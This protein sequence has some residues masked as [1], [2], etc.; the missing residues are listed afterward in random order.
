MP[1]FLNNINWFEKIGLFLFALFLYSNIVS[2]IRYRKTTFNLGKGKIPGCL[3]D[4]PVH[5][6]LPEAYLKSKDK[7]KQFTDLLITGQQ[8]EL[9]LSQD[10]INNLYTKGII[11]NK[12][13]AGRYLYYQIKDNIILERLIE[14]PLF[15]SPKSYRMRIKEI[16]FSSNNL[17][18]YSRIIEEYGRKMNEEK[19]IFSF[20]TSTLILFIFGGL[21]SPDCTFYKHEETVEY[22][23]AMILLEKIKNI[24]IDDDYLILR[25]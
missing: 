10:D 24:E 22:Q 25:T 19:Q 16:S 14:G 23:K 20:Y 1:T 17:E 21:R 15:L 13:T 6:T 9:K 4:F 18:R 8:G 5:T 7:V 2:F 12:Y 11:L 3:E